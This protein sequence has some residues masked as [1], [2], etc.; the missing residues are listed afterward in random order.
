M[1]TL[2]KIA[3]TLSLVGAVAASSVMPALAVDVYVGGNGIY[4]VGHR[5]HDYYNYGGG[6]WRTWNGRRPGW[7][8]QG[9]N[10]APYRGPIYG[11]GWGY[12]R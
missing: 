4:Y 10:C 6:G 8:I 3:A 12:Y 11:S 7:T 9:G 5:H 1:R 2:G